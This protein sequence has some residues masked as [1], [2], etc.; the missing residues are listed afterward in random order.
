MV[1]PTCSSLMRGSGREG[2]GYHHL[3]SDTD[4]RTTPVNPG[5]MGSGNR[6]RD[7]EFRSADHL[8]KHGCFMALQIKMV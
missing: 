7:D 5:L 1:S 2:P 6:D 4:T 8:I 3:D